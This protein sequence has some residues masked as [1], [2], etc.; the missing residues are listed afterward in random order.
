MVF[1]RQP[2]GT[3]GDG[4]ISRAEAGVL[5][6]VNTTAQEVEAILAGRDNSRICLSLVVAY[7]A[8]F[9]TGQT[10]TAFF[11]NRDL[12]VVG[13]NVGLWP[14]HDMNQDDTPPAEF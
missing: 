14:R 3:R 1:K 7:S 6:A 5:A 11:G 2:G 10:S 4:H 9:N 8:M 12:R 13:L